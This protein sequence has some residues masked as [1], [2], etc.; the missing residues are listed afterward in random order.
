MNKKFKVFISTVPFGQ[1]NQYPVELLISNGI[2]YVINPLDRKL[3][4]DELANL[5]GDSDILIAGTEVIDGRVFDKAKNL[6]LI[7]RVG[8]G[9]D[10]V[11]L[12][13]AKKRNISV[14]YTPDAPAPAVAELT[15]GLMLQLLRRIGQANVD[16]RKNNWQR[17]FGYRIS[18]ITI[19]IIGS[20]RIAGRVLRRISSFGTPRILINSLEIDNSIAPSLK[21]EWVSKEYIYKNCDLLSIHVPLTNQTKSMI[22]T[23]ELN[24]MKPHA[25]IVNTSRGGIID[26]DDLYK[27]LRD[28][29]IHSAAIDVF[30][31][32]PYDGPLKD[33]EN[34]YLTCHMGSMSYD[35]RERMEI[36][37]VQEAVNLVKGLPQNREVPQDEYNLRQS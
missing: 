34:C 20:G 21:L 29:R 32:E 13:E 14:T 16:M 35:C 26:E 24:M 2:E 7:A 22:G 18:E 15:I 10:G 36:E 25:M 12:L 27:A 6:K 4:T 23:N 30:E 3:K 1:T 17:S 19:G 37:A 11:D 31:N 28:K 9:L 5:I 33:L 8:I